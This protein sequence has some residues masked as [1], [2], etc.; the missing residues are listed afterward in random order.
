VAAHATAYPDRARNEIYNL[1]FADDIDALKPATPDSDLAVVAADEEAE[2]RVRAVAFRRLKASG[3]APAGD[4]PLLGVVVEMALDEGLDTLAAYADGRIRYINHAGGMSMVEDGTPLRAQVDGLL[5]ASQ[6]VVEKIGPW[7]GD[8]MPP[9][10][11]GQA[12]LTFLVGGD[13]Y[14]GQAPFAALAG[15][16]LAGPVLNSATALLSALVALQGEGA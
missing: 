8:R 7:E 11:T 1:L 14:F 3:Q 12:R 13:I 5:L 9:P 4:A 10:P 6:R 2:S 15:D 16:E